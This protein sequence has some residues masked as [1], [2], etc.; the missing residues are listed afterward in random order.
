MSS[1]LIGRVVGHLLSPPSQDVERHHGDPGTA[2][3][4][5]GKDPENLLLDGGGGTLIGV[6]TTQT[7]EEAATAGVTPA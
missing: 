2:E 5:Q 1:S 6:A 3:N 7:A 4:S